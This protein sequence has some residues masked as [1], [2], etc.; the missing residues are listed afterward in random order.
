MSLVKRKMT[1][2]SKQ[3]IAILVLAALMRIL[4]IWHDYP[5]SYFPDEEHFVNRAVSF[6]SGDLNPHWFHKPAFLMYLLFFEYGFYFVIGKILGIFP[7]VDEFAISFFQNKGPFL[8]IGRFTVA[9]FGIA[10]VFLTY[11][12]GKEHFNRRTGLL[13]AIFLSFVV[14]HI[15]SSQVVKADV[16]S[17]FFTILA[18]YFIAKIYTSGALKYYILSGVFVGLG[19]ATKYYTVLLIPTIVLTHIFYLRK[20]GI[21][22]L[23]NLVNKASIFCALSFL[24]TFFVASPY[25]LSQSQ[26]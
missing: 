24:L 5:Y 8:L 26:F 20:T 18:F 7:S 2:E 12:V 16:P 3:V 13:A 6:G 4:G 22:V 17:T 1:R 23:R 21:P 25:N 11:L 19:T 15:A 14:A 10:T 9:L